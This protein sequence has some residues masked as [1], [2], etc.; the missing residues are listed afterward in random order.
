MRLLLTT[1]N[2]SGL[3]EDLE[4]HLPPWIA[5]LIA[6]VQR[7]QAD[8]IAVHLQEVGGSQWRKEG[9]T[10]TCAVDFATAL[11]N[12]FAT[13]F[14][15][16]GMFINTDPEHDFTA[17]GAVYLVR[18]SDLPYVRIFCFGSPEGRG[19]VSLDEPLVAPTIDQL[20]PHCRHC[21]FPQHF[22]PE[23][24]GW[25][26]KG[27]LHTR[28]E[29]HGRPL[30]LVN[31]HVFHDDSNLVA[32]RR[33]PNTRGQSIYASHRLAA[34]R[35]VLGGIVDARSSGDSGG[36]GEVDADA[37]ASL[38]FAVFLFGDFNFRLDQRAVVQHLCGARGLAMAE[39]HRSERETI[40]IPAAHEV[41]HRFTAA[42]P[43]HT[44]P[45]THTTVVA[46]QSTT[47]REV[48]QRALS[49][50]TRRNLEA[51]MVVRT[52]RRRA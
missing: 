16:S 3:F 50:W 25:S 2:A 28:W 15:C 45:R 18:R 34:L 19:W 42:P 8:F 39:A 52:P 37:T 26:R 23:F 44:V 10:R 35:S 30:D 31:T 43:Y 24:P 1:H 13:D 49:T 14:W 41:R 48:V 5:A 36:S 20:P 51:A 47:R 21:R 6:L 46:S 38:A 29:L 40:H 4:T 32:L 22:F 9:V 7:A 17:L 12:A 11:S 33:A 27:F